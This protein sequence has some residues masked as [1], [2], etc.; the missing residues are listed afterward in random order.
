MDNLHNSI[1]ANARIQLLIVKL[2]VIYP[3]V[4]W[5][6]DTGHESVRKIIVLRNEL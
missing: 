4:L 3:Y 6:P 1:G 2:L 5:D